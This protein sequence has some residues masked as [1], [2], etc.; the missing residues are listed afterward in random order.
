MKEIHQRMSIITRHAENIKAFIDGVTQEQWLENKE[1]RY[2]CI[3]SLMAISENVKEILK[4]DTHLKERHTHIPWSSIARFR[5]K[6]SHHYDKVDFITI[7]EICQK[8]ILALQQAMQHEKS[9]GPY[10]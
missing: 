10:A 4:L 2:A 8:H 5:D 1:K 3:Y 9:G 6:M 7:F